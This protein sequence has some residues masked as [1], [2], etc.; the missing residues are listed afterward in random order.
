MC[1]RRGLEC[2]LENRHEAAAIE[3]NPQMIESLTEAIKKS[4]PIL[5]QV[6]TSLIKF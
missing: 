3:C 2:N 4:Y 5:D 6:G 1:E